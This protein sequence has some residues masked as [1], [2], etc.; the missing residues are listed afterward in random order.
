MPL[1]PP[2]ARLLADLAAAG[3][4]PPAQTAAIAEAER[5]RPFSLHYELRA[6]LYLGVVLLAGGLGVLIYENRASLGHSVL[7]AGIAA[8]MLGSFW[9]AARH[10]PAFT[11]GE[12]PRTRV[13]ADYLLL[14]GCL[15]FLV[16]EGYVQVEYG[17]FGTRY[18]LPALLAAAL[19]L[20]L[21]YRY[22][23][24][25]VL[26][27]GLTALGAW[28][29]VS[30]A[31]LAVLVGTFDADQLAGPALALG[32]AL[33][34]A[35][36]ASERWQRKA[37]FAYTYLLLGANLA[38]LAATRLFFEQEGPLA[39]GWWLLVLALSAGLIWYARRTQ[40]YLFLLLGVAYSYVVLTAGLVR[41]LVVAGLDEALFSLGVLY[42]LLTLA[43]IARFLLNL[44]KI[45]RLT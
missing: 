3:L 28:V 11:W 2:T 18:G 41:L 1:P 35:G 17:V 23:H 7:T 45:L 31:P 37:H 9:Y 19:F 6:L 44:K 33:V 24:R 15:L 12:A 13:A 36:L 14:L 30:V 39:V 22:D 25:G 29:G 4:L 21:A 26:S 32:L 43:G 27:L 20:A 10:R 8:A 38:L 34:A 5:T 16:L 40:S 42:L